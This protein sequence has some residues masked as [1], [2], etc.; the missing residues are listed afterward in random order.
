MISGPFHTAETLLFMI[1]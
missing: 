1:L